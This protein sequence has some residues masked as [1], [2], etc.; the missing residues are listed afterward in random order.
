MAGKPDRTQQWWREQ[1]A[2]LSAELSLEI[3]WCP[4]G[5]EVPD[6]EGGITHVTSPDAVRTILG[7][8]R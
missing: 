6:G 3:C 5:F 8:T 7:G 4:A 2:V 1:A